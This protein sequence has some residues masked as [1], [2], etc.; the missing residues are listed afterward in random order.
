[1]RR[2]LSHHERVRLALEHQ[3]TDRVPIAM[4]CSGVNPPAR[5]EL[6]RFLRDTRGI[7]VDEYFEPILDIKTVEPRYIGPPLGPRKDYWGVIRRPV[8]YGAGE[9]DE[10]E[11]YPLGSAATIDD[12][13]RHRW[14][15]VEW[16]DYSV[17]REQVRHINA[18]EEFGL[19]GHNFNPFETSWY[20]RGLEQCFMDMALAPDMIRLILE[21]VTEFLVAHAERILQAGD[22]QIDLMF[23][24]DDI[25]GQNGLLMSL[26]MWEEFIKPCHVK[27]NTLIHQYGARVIYHS[28]GA[29]MEAVEGLIDMGIDVLQPLQFDARGMDP[30]A[31]KE[32]YGAHLCFQGG[33]S[34]QKTL[35]FGTAEEVRQ[36]ALDR[37]RVLGKGGGYVLGPSHAIQAGT[38]AENILAMF[39][40]A[41]GGR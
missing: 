37:I 40:T 26:S 1:M 17:I 24:A 30:H 2:S 12:I 9:Y 10:I 5:R 21:K 6:E 7:G 39:D 16:F 34:V 3:E 25:G 31:L 41:M 15:S 33:I 36:E 29:I 11:H 14:P 23:T 4:V 27:I 32:L 38:P 28:D 35:P 20:M 19:M 8:S 22:G 13:A 18:T